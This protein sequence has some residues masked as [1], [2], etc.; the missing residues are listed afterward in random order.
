MANPESKPEQ[1]NNPNMHPSLSR[2]NELWV[3]ALG[4]DLP[5]GV[6]YMRPPRSKHGYL[7]I[8]PEV[9]YPAPNEYRGSQIASFLLNE[10]PSTDATKRRLI[11][12]DNSVSL[13]SVLDEAAGATDSYE[14]RPDQSQTV[15]KLGQLL[16]GIIG[17]FEEVKD[18]DH[19][20]PEVIDPTNILIEKETSKDI[21]FK[22]TP[23]LELRLITNKDERQ[24]AWNR[25]HK[26]FLKSLGSYAQNAS[27]GAFVQALN[28]SVNYAFQK[29]K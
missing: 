28:I 26:E 18:H 1:I 10:L 7:E 3:L 4:L 17:T 8:G 20:L 9:S 13:P 5:E 14:Y 21:A 11:V 6:A 16:R 23:A 27:R 22:V 15:G 25:L 29:Q 12:P 24:E 2:G 19:V